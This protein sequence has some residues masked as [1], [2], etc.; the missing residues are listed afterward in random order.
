MP[1]R[2]VRRFRTLL[3]VGATSAMLAACTPGWDVAVTGGPTPPPA[4]A[5]PSTAGASEGSRTSVSSGSAGE[6][7]TPV[8]T[9]T[10]SESTADPR[11]ADDGVPAGLV[12]FYD[13]HLQWG[14]CTTFAPVG[15]DKYP[16][17]STD[18]TC[19]HLAAPLDYDHPG[20]PRI[21][22]AVMR[23]RA[24]GQSTA[25]IGSLVMNPGGP[26]G[27][28]IAHLAYLYQTHQASYIGSR[29]DL[30]AFD[31]RGVGSSRPLI[32]CRTDAEQDA[33]RANPMRD[34]TAAAFAAASAR[35]RTAAEHCLTRTVPPAGTDA[36]TFLQHV[37]THEVIRD[38]DVLRSVLGDRRLT[39]L[40]GS[41]GTQLGA[42]YAELFPAKVRAMVLDSP[43]DPAEDGYALTLDWQNGVQQAFTDFVAWCVQQ[44]GCGLGDDA[45]KALA[46][47]HALEESLLSKPVRLPDLRVLS[48][49]DLIEGTYIA[50]G[51]GAPWWAALFEGLHKLQD[52]D[53]TTM[54]ALADAS[55][56]RGPTGHYSGYYD[57]NLV[58]LC[59]DVPVTGATNVKVATVMAK[60]DR[61]DDESVVAAGLPNYCDF[62]P[63]TPTWTP[64]VP[65]VPGLVTPLVIATT[66]D[67]FTPYTEG[68]AMA[69]E[70][71]G[72]L[73]TVEGTRHGSYLSEVGC[74]DPIANAYLLSST[75]PKDGAH[76][77]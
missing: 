47:F 69:K 64:H 60:T 15:A 12:P 18:L 25:R 36:K 76:C 74:V 62:L 4:S 40:G 56:E 19:T 49:R 13:Q 10:T 39:Y 71:G 54:M 14:S 17:D 11:P 5:S 51:G 68:V 33:E 30:V 58:L 1:G 20:G 28:G 57:A 43:V 3:V 35:I 29:L 7:T 55:W 23:L 75:L 2:R 72:R 42:A 50:L 31:P 34:H 53:G 8:S 26:G 6:T 52:G 46:R 67:P 32:R 70:L 24:T 16:Y 66:H 77:G 45:G 9:T 61:F 65:K 59:L 44:T 21:S 27:S 22:V 48:G 41:Y 73:L 38:I 37:G 63:V